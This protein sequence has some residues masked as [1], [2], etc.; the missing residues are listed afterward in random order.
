MPLSTKTKQELREIPGAIVLLTLFLSLY[1]ILGSAIW[2]LH[3]VV[4]PMSPGKLGRFLAYHNPFISR[5]E[6]GTALL[7]M[8][9]AYL[10]A[11]CISSWVT[12]RST[13]APEHIK[14]R[15]KIASWISAAIGLAA[16]FL[17]LR[18]DV[19]A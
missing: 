10:S 14:R 8:T 2:L 16:I 15:V 3:K 1:T 9:V 4:H 5:S 13:G 6:L 18:T 17:A 12:Y 7:T 11:M 19:F